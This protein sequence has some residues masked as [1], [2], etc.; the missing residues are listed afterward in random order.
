MSQ[1]A[2]AAVR[3]LEPLDRPGAGRGWNGLQQESTLGPAEVT[4][5]V[6]TVEAG[7]GVAAIH[8]SADHRH[9]GDGGRALCTVGIC[10]HRVD[11]W[12]T[13]AADVATGGRR[14]E[15]FHPLPDVPT[16]ISA[17]DDA[18]HFLPAA[19]PDVPRDQVASRAI[20]REAI[21]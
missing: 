21:R 5:D 3:Q 16:V 11:E 15:A 14:L 9:S 6:T 19:L 8:G 18:V 7:H 2:S 13:Q 20:E 12:L 17:P 10:E 4:K 1:Q